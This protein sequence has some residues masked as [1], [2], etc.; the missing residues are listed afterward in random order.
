VPRANGQVERVN[1]TLVPLLTKLSAPKPGEWYRHLSAVQMCL[2]A[3]VQ[4]SIGMTPFRVLLGVHPR[5]RDNPDIR[6]LL[7]DEIVMSFDDNRTELRM[8][9][10]GNIEKIQKE[11]MKTY[12]KKRKNPLSYREGDLVAIKRTQQGPCLKLAHKYFGPYEIIKV[13]RNHRYLLRKVGES[14]GPIQT[15]SAADYM[16]PWIQDDDYEDISGDD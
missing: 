4:R 7:E 16:K 10:R 1:R 6:E 12:N 5:I 9:A 15:S 8:E 11:N 3:T 14:E 2:N 13:L